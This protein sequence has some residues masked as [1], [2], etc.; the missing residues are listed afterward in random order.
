M[1]FMLIHITLPT[2]SLP[3]KMI[4]VPRGVS[5]PKFINQD[6]MFIDFVDVENCAK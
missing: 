3:P 2:Y 4:V 6:Q 5:C 1:P